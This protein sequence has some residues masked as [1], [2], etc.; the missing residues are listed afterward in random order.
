MASKKELDEFQ[1]W[2]ATEGDWVEE[3]NER[4]KGMSGVQRIERDGKTLYVKR[5]V[6]HLF[7]SLRYPFGRPTIVREIQVINELAAAGVIVPKIV[8]GKALQ[9][10]GE[11]RALLVT[12]DMKDFV[13]ISD[14]YEQNMHLDCS[15]EVKAEMF[16]Q[17]A[18]AFKKMHS[19]NRQHGC[20]YVR[21]IYVKSRGE[22]LA[23]FLDLE[24]SRRRWV[25]QKAVLHD[26]KQLEKY[27]SPI[28]P[29]DW[30]KV[31]EQ[32]YSL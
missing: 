29:E 14:W 26:F 16:K 15:P 24:K 19:V 4:R 8:Y 17:I 25:R 21:H 11:W 28:P 5:Q 3:P 1:R 2:W 32:Y 22:V 23:G 10:N 6:A 18:V 13:S 20:C 9:I 27:L 7:H 31:K 30:Q 12:E